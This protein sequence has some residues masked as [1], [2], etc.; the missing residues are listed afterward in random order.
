MIDKISITN[1]KCFENI[2][3]RLHDLNVFAGLN[4]A[5]KST[6]IQSL[7]LFKQSQEQD[8]LVRNVVLN[9]HYVS[10]GV[11]K[12]ILNEYTSE[13]QLK[14]CFE[15]FSGVTSVLIDYEEDRDILSATLEN[16]KIINSLNTKFEYIG[17]GRLS[18]QTIYEKS[19]VYVDTKTQL[20]I[21]GEYTAHYI[22]LHENDQVGIT[23]R[24]LLAS[25]QYW[26][27][28]ISPGIRLNIHSIDNTD[29]DQIGYRYSDLRTAVTSNEYRPTN[30]GF[31]ISYVL[32]V[33]TAIIKAQP[34]SILILENPEAH[35]HPQGQR[36]IG[37]LIA[38]CAAGGVQVLLETHSDHVLNGIRIAVKK[39]IIEAEQTRLFFFERTLR[40]NKIE[41]F[42]INPNILSNGKLDFWPDGFF[43]EWDKA[44]DEI[45]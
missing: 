34:G 43:D 16:N 40:D 3:L 13:E 19:S 6:A 38:R 14:I 42:A 29:F 26:L 30:V 45:L 39:K 2:D 20:G 36:K 35:L 9:G 17:A 8:P 33:V 5:G 23:G 15:D 11:G 27:G 41:H 24:P 1:F 25:I 18:P 10:L 12:D 28:I 4:S 37:E 31:G 32:P 44:L 7:L 22:S 21:N